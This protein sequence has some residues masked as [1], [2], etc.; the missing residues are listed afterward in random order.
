M[1]LS[2][3]SSIQNILEEFSKNNP[4]HS[5]KKINFYLLNYNARDLKNHYLVDKNMTRV[6]LNFAPHAYLY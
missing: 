5:Y 1:T 4:Y 2:M 3:P 6:R